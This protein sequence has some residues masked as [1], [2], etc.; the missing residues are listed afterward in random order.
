M[1]AASGDRCFG[2]APDSPPEAWDRHVSVGISHPSDDPAHHR[3]FAIVAARHEGMG[4]VAHLTEGN[5]N[6]QPRPETVGLQIPDRARAFPTVA[7]CLGDA[8]AMLVRMVDGDANT[9]AAGRIDGR[10]PRVNDR[11]KQFEVVFVPTDGRPEEAL[12]AA[13]DQKDAQD[14]FAGFC[15]TLN[16]IEPPARRPGNVE[17]RDTGPL[18]RV[19][20]QFPVT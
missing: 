3:T 18:R 9:A 12:D 5:H 19:M 10:Q 7:E 17:L 15:A 20:E 13:V 11:R 6:D 8:L 16:G 4:W 1:T 2:H 14:L